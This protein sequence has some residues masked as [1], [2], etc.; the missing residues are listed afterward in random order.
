MVEMVEE[1]LARIE[2]KLDSLNS[3]IEDVEHLKEFKWKMIGAV[4]VAFGILIPLYTAII[5]YIIQHM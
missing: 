1:R 2:Q 4:G 5:T 3:I